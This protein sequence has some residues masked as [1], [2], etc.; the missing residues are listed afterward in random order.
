MVSLFKMVL[1]FLINTLQ[2]SRFKTDLMPLLKLMLSN[3]E[4]Y[5]S[6]LDYVR[7]VKSV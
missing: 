2:K 5:Y 3:I 4:Y 1:D 6:Y 7:K